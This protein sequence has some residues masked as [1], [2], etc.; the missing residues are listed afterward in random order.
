[1][2]QQ[3]SYVEDDYEDDEEEGEE[4]GEGSEQLLNNT[5]RV[6][7]STNMPPAQIQSEEAVRR[8]GHIFNRPI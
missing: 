6:A 4:E 5:P 3:G 8:F 2:F 1:M 7:S